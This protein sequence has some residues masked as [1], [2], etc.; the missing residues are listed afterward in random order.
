MTRNGGKI[1]MTFHGNRAELFL[2]L[3]HDQHERILSDMSE[4]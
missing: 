3:E 2:P 1:H 4:R